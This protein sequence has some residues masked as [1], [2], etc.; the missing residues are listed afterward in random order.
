MMPF[1][2]P[3]IRHF[4]ELSTEFPKKDAR[5]TILKNILNLLTDD[6]KGKIIENINFKYLAIGRLLWETPWLP[7]DQDQE[8]SHLIAFNY[9]FTTISQ[10]FLINVGVSGGERRK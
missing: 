6:R 3:F 5:L 10:S 8:N 2:A 4:M 7:H 9:I 1:A